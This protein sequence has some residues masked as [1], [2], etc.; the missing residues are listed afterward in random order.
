MGRFDSLYA[1]LPGNPQLRG[2]QFEHVVKWFLEN[3]PVYAYELK[4]VWLWSEW[5]CATRSTSATGSRL[6]APN[7]M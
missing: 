4:N 2:R 3:D 5:E 6:T 7:G 1:N